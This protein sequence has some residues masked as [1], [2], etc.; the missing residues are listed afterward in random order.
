MTNIP[1]LQM[2]WVRHRRVSLDDTS[3]KV[4]AF[5][6]KQIHQ[7]VRECSRALDL[8]EAL[9]AGYEI[10]NLLDPGF[11]IHEFENKLGKSSFILFIK[12]INL[13]FP[14]KIFRKF[15]LWV[16]RWAVLPH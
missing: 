10:N 3:P 4:Y 14:K 12:K 5:R 1:Q 7:R 2:G 6:N 8:I 15:A 13:N 9:N 11:N 16:I